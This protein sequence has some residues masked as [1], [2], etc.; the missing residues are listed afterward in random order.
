M[1]EEMGAGPDVEFLD[2]PVNLL[3][4]TNLILYLRQHG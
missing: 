3:G 2:L 4:K 1:F